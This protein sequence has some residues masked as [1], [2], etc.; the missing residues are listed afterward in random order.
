LLKVIEGRY[1]PRTR[2]EKS[3]PNLRAQ[4]E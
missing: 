1:D 3:T 2:R 4:K